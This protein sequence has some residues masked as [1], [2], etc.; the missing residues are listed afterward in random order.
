MFLRSLWWVLPHF[1]HR[2]FK[3]CCKLFGWPSRSKSSSTLNTREM[4]S[5]L[6]IHLYSHWRNLNQSFQ[7]NYLSVVIPR[8][9]KAAWK[10]QSRWEMPPPKAGRLRA[11]GPE[12]HLLLKEARWKSNMALPHAAGWLRYAAS[13]SQSSHTPSASKSCNCTEILGASPQGVL[14]RPT[15]SSVLGV[16]MTTGDRQSLFTCN[17]NSKGTKALF[18]PSRH[19]QQKTKH[20]AT[21]CGMHTLSTR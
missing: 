8:I 17:R 2:T 7:G 20:S 11:E 4:T 1:L 12:R 18:G 19:H 16:S 15:N 14:H 21:A 5:V 13:S 9:P 3:N 10:S 6:T